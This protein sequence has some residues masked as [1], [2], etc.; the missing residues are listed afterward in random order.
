MNKA[1]VNNLIIAMEAQVKHHGLNLMNSYPNDL[2][3]HDRNALNVIASP[4]ARIGWMVG[5]RHTHL[6]S[7]GIHPE[8]NDMLPTLTNLCNSDKFYFIDIN[9]MEAGGFLMKQVSRDDF[10]KPWNEK[11][12]FSRSGEKFNFVV[13]HGKDVIGS[14]D[15]DI[16]GNMES[17]VFVCNVHPVSGITQLERTALHVWASKGVNHAAGTLFNRSELHWNEAKMVAHG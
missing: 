17:R 16:A 1:L 9:R 13:N 5:D 15:I 11:C 2:L 8:D 4:G 10:K 14:V 6:V 12:N 7:I 3:I